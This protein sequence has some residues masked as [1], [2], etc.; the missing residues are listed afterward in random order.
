[1]AR[2]S[3]LR[4]ADDPVKTIKLITGFSIVLLNVLSA[5]AQGTFQ[6]LNFESANLS[7]PSG[8]Y[9][10][11]P[12]TSALPDWSASIGNVAV[13]EIWANGV[14]TGEATIDV[15][16]PGWNYI[17]PGIIDGNYTVF[18][19]AFDTGQ[20]NV[21]LWQNGTIPANAASLQFCAWDYS[22]VI[23][24]VSFAGN[25]LS[26]VVLGSGQS[27]SG[28]AYTVYGI[29]ITPYAGQTGQLEFTA[30]GGQSPNPFEL[31]D[32]SFV[33]TPEPSIVALTAIGGLLFG[34]RKW[35]ARP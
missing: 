1:M 20:G 9:N 5:H 8:P 12:I 33:L 21:S 19:Q 28:Q 10:E 27:P 32:I 30:F 16:G 25:N 2:E 22:S 34:A 4:A 15:F 26:P 35:F 18:L 31:D 24:S 3:G 29:N 23:D 13:T 7:N 17:D 6:N 11:V 14:S